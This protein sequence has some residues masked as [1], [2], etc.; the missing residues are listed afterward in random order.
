MKNKVNK[1]SKEVS[2]ATRA[3]E[4]WNK[5]NIFYLGGAFRETKNE[6]RWRQK[7]GWDENLILKNQNKERNFKT[8]R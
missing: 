6:I 7:R 3:W 1:K 2:H 4:G 8:L 5:G